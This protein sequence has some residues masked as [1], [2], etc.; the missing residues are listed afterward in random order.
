MARSLS[1][2]F[3]RRPSLDD[4]VEQYGSAKEAFERGNY[5]VSLIKA[6]NEDD[7]NIE[8][9]SMIMCG[10]RV[11]SV[12]KA[13]KKGSVEYLFAKWCYENTKINT[14]LLSN[15]RLIYQTLF[16]YYKYE[17]RRRENAQYQISYLSCSQILMN[18]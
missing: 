15:E 16:L 5:Y 3:E 4:I 10:S 2:N 6:Q 12:E 11:K 7:S 1:P 8:A 13:L 17:K 9:A 18:V 14:H